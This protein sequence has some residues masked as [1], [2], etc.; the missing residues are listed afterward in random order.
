MPKTANHTSVEDLNR[1]NLGKLPEHLGLMITEV[2]DGRV[3]GRF[4][5]RPDLVAHTGYLLAGAV[6][7]VADILCAY[8]VSTAWPEGASGFTTAEV[9]CNFTGILREGEAIC[10]ATLLH[11]GRTTQVWDAAVTDAA[12]GRLMAAFRCTQVILYPRT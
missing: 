5:A 8:G 12:T 9:K 7:S 6:L 2:A 3:V 10:T 1:A 11:G 4:S